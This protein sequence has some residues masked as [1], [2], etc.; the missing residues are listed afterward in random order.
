MFGWKKANFE[1]YKQAYDM[2]GGGIVTSPEVLS[3]LHE[4][5]ELNEKYFIKTD[6]KN[7]ITAA[8]C[9]WEDSH[10]AGDQSIVLKH[11][12]NKYPINFDEL[13]FPTNKKNNIFLP[14]KTK[15]LSS[16][17]GCEVINCSHRLNASREICLL[18]EPSKKTT[19]TR[20]RELKKFLKIGGEVINS[21]EFSVEDLVEI[22]D[23]LYF[24]RRNNHIL[25]KEMIELLKE[26]PMLRFGN[27][28]FLNGNPVAMQYIL[29]KENSHWVNY[30]YYNLGRKYIGI[31]GIP[32]GTISIWINV[33]EAIKYTK[34]KNLGLRFSFGRPTFDYKERWCKRDKLYKV[35]TI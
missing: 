14:F 15:F 10:L 7:K 32:L 19:S 22:Y 16:I 18:K 20:E 25:K 11:S 17:N 8:I 2:F 31:S 34:D 4:R 13:L 6:R 1:N 21:L 33:K 35:I 30:D 23:D 29:K 5:F 28:L 12:I 9:T 27:L 3:F 24:S 26:L